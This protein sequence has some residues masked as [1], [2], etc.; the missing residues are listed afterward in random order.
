MLAV[1]FPKR[2][3]VLLAAEEDTVMGAWRCFDVE[4]LEV[5]ARVLEVGDDFARVLELGDVFVRAVLELGD[6]F[7][8]VV[9]ELCDVFAR[10]LELCDSFSV[11]DDG[12][13]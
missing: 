12:P 8:R 2:E 4:P 1:V 10:V 13:D 5:F 7:V 9:L 11:C 6:V 3:F